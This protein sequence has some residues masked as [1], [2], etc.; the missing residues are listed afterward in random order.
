MR[1]ISACKKTQFSNVLNS[2]LRNASV[3]PDGR[4]IRF[5]HPLRLNKKVKI[6]GTA[7][8]ICFVLV[9]IFAFLPKG[10]QTLS[11]APQP[12]DDPTSTPTN[13][14]NQTVNQ[15][16]KPTNSPT[17]TLSQFT[18]IIIGITEIMQPSPTPT[19]PGPLKNAQEVNSTIW[20]AIA[21]NAWN[22]YKP[23]VGV[24]VNTG[25][26][27]TTES[28][29]YITDWDVG[30]YIQAVVDAAK[31]GLVA[32]N[33][34][35]GFN[36]RMDKVLSFLENREINSTTNYP[37]WFYQAT[38][39][40][41][42]RQNSDKATVPVD[43]V[44]TGRLFVALNN[45]RVYAPN[46][47]ARVN[48]FVFN[49]RSNYSVLVPYVK[50]DC[51]T[52]NSI[53]TY[54]VAS[55]FAF[56][57]P[58]ELGGYPRMVLNNILSSANVTTYGVSLPLS[59]L[60]G[61]PLLGSLFDLNNNDSRLMALA[62]QVFLAHEA[63]YNT[64]GNFRAFGEGPE[65]DTDWQWEWVVFSD[66]RTWITLN[67]FYQNVTTTPIIYTK[68]AYGLMALRNT[69]FA[70][71]MCTYLEQALPYPE[72]GYGEG[73]DERGRALSIT[74]SLTNG[75]ILAAAVYATKYK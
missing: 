46:L 60:T 7:V 49:G 70:I 26:P 25:I 27:W 40:K 28:S 9:S 38:D 73:I 69:T 45:L 37:Y 43:S 66:G 71:N 1:Q 64:T 22:Y 55:G 10:D 36:D 34:S 17:N 8:I 18:N 41:N 67:T 58:N 12:T 56:F 44:D 52:S 42:W 5:N 47:A 23:G 30:V 65:L 59:S 39:G 2:I 53:Y 19:P 4:K 54:Y 21:S 15:T 13:H 51:L 32:I 6:V 75:F 72:R 68:I 35:W 11:A 74:G 3:I 62:N 31:L 57:W 20:L 24:D 48:N 14:H 50:D 61:D 63:Y 16:P 29:P 33:G